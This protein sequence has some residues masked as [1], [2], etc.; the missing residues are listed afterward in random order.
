[1]TFYTNYQTAATWGN[2]QLILCNNIVNIDPSIVD[3]MRFN[4]YPCDD[5]GNVS[6]Y[7]IDI[8]QWYITDLSDWSVEWQEKTFDLKYTYSDLLDC[9]ILC[10]DHYGTLWNSVSCEVKSQSWIEVNKDLEYKGL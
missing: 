10:V 1:M 8:Y 9:Y 6:D 4:Y 2:C 3:N 5:D 7:P